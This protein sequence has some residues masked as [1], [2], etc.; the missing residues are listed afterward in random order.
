MTLIL[1]EGCIFTMKSLN[2]C[3]NSTPHY[4]NI[5]IIEQRA[6]TALKY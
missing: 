6:E 3:I 2:M 5:K 4:I 1:Q